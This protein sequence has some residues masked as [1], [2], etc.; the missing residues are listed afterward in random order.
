P[1]AGVAASAA[2][3]VSV[4]GSRASWVSWVGGAA[5][6]RKGAA[7]VKGGIRRVRRMQSDGGW[8]T[9]GERRRLAGCGRVVVAVQ[10][11]ILVTGEGAAARQRIPATVRA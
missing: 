7:S 4:S 2:R 5:A 9:H 3:R 11:A 10:I 6:A 8:R 1:A